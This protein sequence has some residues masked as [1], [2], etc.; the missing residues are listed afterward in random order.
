MVTGSGRACYSSVHYY[1]KPEPYI[2]LLRSTRPAYWAKLAYEK[3]WLSR[4]F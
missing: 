3:Y 4:W 2:T 1:K